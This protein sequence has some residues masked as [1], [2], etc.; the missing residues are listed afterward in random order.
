MNWN[1]SCDENEGILETLEKDCPPGAVTYLVDAPLVAKD[2]SLPKVLCLTLLLESEADIIAGILLEPPSTNG[3]ADCVMEE[4]S[5]TTPEV[6]F[7]SQP[8]QPKGEDK[9]QS[10]L[11]DLKVTLS[12][13]RA[14][15]KR[16][17]AV[18]QEEM[19]D[20]ISSDVIEKFSNVV[21]TSAEVDGS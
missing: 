10:Q 16:A 5:K 2:I 11:H 19:V 13:A 6:F 21:P 7:A 1:D 3:Y 12:N 18:L 4:K 14:E 20:R 8:I 17:I 15:F 9:L